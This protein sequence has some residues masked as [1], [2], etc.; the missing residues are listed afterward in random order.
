MTL[1]CIEERRSSVL[2]SVSYCRS[3]NLGFYIEMRGMGEVRFNE[4]MQQ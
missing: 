4:R 1:T 2:M 3:V